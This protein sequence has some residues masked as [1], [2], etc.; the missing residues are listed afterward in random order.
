M[1]VFNPILIQNLSESST[2]EP[3]E[4]FKGFKKTRDFGDFQVIIDVD[5]GSHIA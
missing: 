4:D 1:F 2:S 5:L 3:V